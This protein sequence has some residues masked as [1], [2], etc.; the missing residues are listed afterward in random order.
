MSRI[1]GPR[2]GVWTPVYGTWGATT[3]PEDPFDAS[4]ERAKRLVLS[5]EKLGYDS[6][7]IAQHIVN[8]YGHEFDI[9]ETWTAAAGLASLTSSIEI[10]AAI[11]P[12]LFHPMVLAKQALGIEEISGGR[13][14]INVVNAWYKPE[15]LQSGIPFAEH[16]ERYIYGTEWL[17]IV[18]S[19]L[20]GEKTSFEGKYFHVDGIELNPKPKTRQRPAIYVG[21]ESEPARDLAAGLGDVWFINGQPLENVERLIRSVA[22]RKR[23]GVPVRFG[24]SA[25][26]IA[27][28]TEEEAQAELAKAWEYAKAD[29]P[30]NEQLF[31]HADQK[32]VMFQ[33][34]AKYPAIG[35]NGGTAAGLV[36]SY[37]QVAERIAAFHEIGVEL[38]MLQ[39]Q[40]LESELER[41][42]R[43]VFPRVRS[44]NPVAL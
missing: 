7:L 26:V 36:G 40:P 28:E 41:F 4:W 21:G 25:F 30:L 6:T 31:G 8:P 23:E 2:F 38:F 43:E 42:A 12:T 33:T 20:S 16:D 44:L 19:L 9:L 17:T 29:Q 11:K 24:L 34:I 1:A 35:T 5:A 13:F 27:R 18:R 15:L 32:A 10:I 37:D 22:G 3:H 14:S 39:F